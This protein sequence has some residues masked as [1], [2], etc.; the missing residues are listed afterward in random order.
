MDYGLLLSLVSFSTLAGL[1]L[2]SIVDHRRGERHL[3]EL[4]HLNA[5]D[6]RQFWKDSAERARRDQEESRRF[7]ADHD[8][9]MRMILERVERKGK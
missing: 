2:Y 5:M 4:A 3:R 6:S 9:L 8:L 1:I 7:L